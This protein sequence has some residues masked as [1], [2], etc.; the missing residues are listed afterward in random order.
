MGFTTT[1]VQANFGLRLLC[2][3]AAISTSARKLDANF[4]NWRELK[5]EGELK[6]AMIRGIRVKMCRLVLVP[7]GF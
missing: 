4:A 1:D 3:F 7:F 2:L 6:F 5:N